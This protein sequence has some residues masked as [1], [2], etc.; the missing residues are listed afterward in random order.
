MHIALTGA[1]GFLGRALLDQATEYPEISVTAFTSRRE[2]LCE[3]YCRWTNVAVLGNEGISGFSFEKT[4]VLVNCAFPMDGKD[5][6]LAVGLQFVRQVLESAVDS[7]VG[8]VINISSQSVYSQSRPEAA[9]E[10][11]P[12]VP[13]SKYAVG[14][15]ASELLTNTICREIPHTSLRLASLIG[16]DL[17]Q[18]I[19]NRFVR[20]ILSGQP[21]HITGGSQ[22]FG[23]LDVRDAAAGILKMARHP[24][25]DWA[26]VYNLG[27][28]GGETLLE[29][30]RCVRGLGMEYGFASPDIAIAP[31]AV[32]HNSELDCRRFQ[33]AFDWR[34][35]YPLRAS[36]A[37]MFEAEL[38]RR[39]I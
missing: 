22:R 39:G 20:Q 32:W 13:E 8:A 25:E 2:L 15:F 37:D 18:R 4:D 3:Q 33:S 24:P 23:F 26:Q 19:V 5:A 10:H 34:P 38:R 30:A 17:E 31:S 27:R 29:I 7:G 28:S 11:T 16:T 36:V 9:D 6:Q 35:R 21:L 1:G 12:V 14:K